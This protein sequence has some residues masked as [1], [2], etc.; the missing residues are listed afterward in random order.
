MA[1]P[2]DEGVI[3]SNPDVWNYIEPNTSEPESEP[4]P[5]QPETPAPYDTIEVAL[6]GWTYR[7]WRQWLGEDEQEQRKNVDL[8]TDILQRYDPSATSLLEGSKSQPD[9]PDPYSWVFRFGLYGDPAKVT[10]AIENL[11]S[12]FL[13]ITQ[14][15]KVI[16]G[17]AKAL[18][19]RMDGTEEAVELPKDMVSAD[20]A[21][22]TYRLLD[23]VQTGGR[24]KSSPETESRTSELRQITS[25]ASGE[26]CTAHGKTGEEHTDE[27]REQDILGVKGEEGAQ[28]IECG[29]PMNPVQSMLSSSSGKCADCIQK[30]HNRA[31]G[32][33]E[34]EPCQKHNKEWKDH[35]FDEAM[36]DMTREVDTLYEEQAWLP[37][38]QAVPKALKE[39][40]PTD[41][42]P[43]DT[44]GLPYTDDLPTS[45]TTEFDKM[46]RPI[47][48]YTEQEPTPEPEPQP[49]WGRWRKDVDTYNTEMSNLID[50]VL[51]IGDDPTGTPEAI[52]K[53]TK[54]AGD[55]MK[56]IV[57]WATELLEKVTEAMKT[58]LDTGQDSEYIIDN[59]QNIIDYG[60]RF[61]MLLIQN[62]EKAKSMD[63]PQ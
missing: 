46:G 12:Q 57:D 29:A 62:E 48:P 44:K 40:K 9:S 2:P 34:E 13:K 31:V 21:T 19:T 17:T 43:K 33:G 16:P 58:S 53:T 25:P 8:L 26:Y 47:I 4:T 10:E 37:G 6:D 1:Q 20:I 39:G 27:E 54:V 7:L 42:L 23:L 3:P 5:Q 63:I 52:E 60:N 38:Y 45:E 56:E 32:K 55:R 36:E 28:C 18:V 51:Q 15:F 50:T 41:H 14:K 49:N 35:S 61:H 59:L 22:T 30:A 11:D 24:V